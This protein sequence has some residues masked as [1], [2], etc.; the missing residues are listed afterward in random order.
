MK[1]FAPAV[2]IFAVLCGGAA[3][4]NTAPA[5]CADVMLPATLSAKIILGRVANAVPGQLRDASLPTAEEAAQLKTFR[6]APCRADKLA[7]MRSFY[8][9][10]AAL[11]D[12][13]TRILNDLIAR[14]ISFGS[15]NR[16]WTQARF[17]YL[18]LT[19]V[20]L[21]QQT[22]TAPPPPDLGLMTPE[23]RNRQ[24]AAGVAES[25]RMLDEA[26]KARRD[27]LRP[28]QC[29]SSP[30]P[31]PNQPYDPVNPNCN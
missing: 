11:E 13:N 10:E 19:G 26:E 4:Q 22:Q 6:D 21:E 3:A 1:I 14:K 23:E 27:S 31:L 2:L 29:P 17:D 8:P 30:V 7:N 12:G 24:D 18:R 15:A 16:Q 9:R 28:V 5:A 20:I 25:Q